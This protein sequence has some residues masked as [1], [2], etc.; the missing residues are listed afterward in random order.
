MHLPE[1]RWHWMRDL[2]ERRL[3]QLP[4]SSWRLLAFL[5]LLVL[6]LLLSPYWTLWRLSRAAASP[7][8]AALAAYV[9]LDAVREEIRR[10][11]NKDV[12][13]R[14]GEVSDPFIEWIAEGLQTNGTDA[15]DHLVDLEWIAQ[16]LRPDRYRSQSLFE[17]VSYAFYD[18]PHGFLVR[19]DGGREQP[20]TLLL[21]PTPVRWRITAAYY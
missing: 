21:R 8:P 11:L 10:R 18:V 5:G 3:P 4:A 9:D 17:D 15:I 7:T 20:V 2:R 16:L 12:S 6:A 13:S 14:I 19:L 1:P